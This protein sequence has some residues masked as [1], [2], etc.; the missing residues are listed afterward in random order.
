MRMISFV[1]YQKK[2]YYVQGV[3]LDLD[4]ECQLISKGKRSYIIILTVICFGR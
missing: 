3:E 4:C 2:Q 1:C